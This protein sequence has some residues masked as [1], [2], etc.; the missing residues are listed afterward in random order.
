MENND[1]VF[2]ILT[3]EDINLFPSIEEY[4]KDLEELKNMDFSNSTQEE[5]KLAVYGKTKLFQHFAIKVSPT[6]LNNQTFY[7]CRYNIPESEDLSIIRTHSYPF[8]NPSPCNGRANLKGQSVFYCSDDAMAAMFEARP[9]AGDVGYLSVW[10][11][12]ATKE[13]KV[14]MFLPV[15]LRPDNPW[16]VVSSHFHT[17]SKNDYLTNARSKAEHL[18]YLNYFLWNL[19]TTE[20]YPITSWIANELLYGRFNCDAILYPSTLTGQYRCNWAIHPNSADLILRLEKVLRFHVTERNGNKMMIK[21]GGKLGI[22]ENNK[23][24][25]KEPTRDEINFLNDFRME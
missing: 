7:R 10:K 8:P 23:I 21:A 1:D 19:F 17:V 11:P 5:I 6:N 20:N 24:K 13:T 15:N 25:W 16:H 3:E 9:K 22:M 18:E 4:K 2:N 14:S 12:I